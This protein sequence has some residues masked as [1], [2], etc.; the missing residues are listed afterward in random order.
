MWVNDSTLETA[1]IRNVYGS[2]V[3]G[4]R[5]GSRFRAES[6]NSITVFARSR[7]TSDKVHKLTNKSTHP[8]ISQ[9]VADHAE[10]RHTVVFLLCS[11]TIFLFG[12][13]LAVS[14]S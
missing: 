11:P 4:K 14:L 3:D 9:L 5:L 13:S 10:A 2:C 12:R 1:W 7:F 6:K 8:Q